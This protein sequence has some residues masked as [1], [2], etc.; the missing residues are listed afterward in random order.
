M[1]T[2]L[3]PHLGLI[4]VAMLLMS[5][6]GAMLGALSYMVRPMFDD[7]FL[8]GDGTAMVLVA[9]VIM[10]LFLT[11]AVAGFGQLVIV[12]R[13]G[14]QVKIAMQS[15]LLRHILRLDSAYFHAHPPG[16]MLERVR[17]DTEALKMVWAT[18]IAS[19]VRDIV[20]LVS[21]FT[22][23]VLI[24]PLWT[25][26]A[27]A[28]VPALVLPIIALLRLT[29]RASEAARAAASDLVI[30]LDEIFHGI[31]QI[32]LNTQEELQAR[33]FEKVTVGYLRAMTQAAAGIAGAP[34]L[35]DIVAG[36]GFV[37]VMIYGGSQIMDGTKTVG[38]FMSFFTAMALVF[39]PLRRL[40]RVGGAWAQARV[41]LMR[42]RDILDVQ[43]T[44][45]DPKEPRMPGS[46]EAQGDITFEGVAFGYDGVPV[47]RGL[48]LTARA[49]ETTA[50]VGPSGAGKSTVFNLLARLADV[51]AGAVRLGGV[52]LRE[53]DVAALRGLLSV[54]SQEAG[55][56]DETIRAN[57][58][59]GRPEAS[60]AEVEAAA[61][62]AF[63][64]DFA[65]TLPA[66]L[67][68]PVGPRGSN[69]SGGQRQRVAIARALLRDAPILLLDEPTSALDTRSE[70]QVQAALE[71]LSRG[72]TTLVIAHR[73]STI[74]SARHIVVLDRGA[75]VDE[76]THEELLSR[77]GLYAGLYAMQFRDDDAGAAP[78]APAAP[79]GGTDVSG[80]RKREGGTA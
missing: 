68:T 59:F 45:S 35:L 54:V 17:G 77:G 36:I 53:F 39:E 66:G 6:E 4:L 5:V 20:A 32:K 18:V 41:S 43:P 65:Q 78:A 30:R 48:N 72:R 70:A 10:A 34:A 47:L 50:L 29:R 1:A 79:G 64:W 40:G 42:L 11:R 75:V 12:T 23:A 52:D 51:H 9:V 3:R 13:V 49:G 33:R 73:L 37:G 60:A 44:I 19:S 15:D 38:E 16:E 62:A 46:A 71:R 61:R 69:L 7:V 25:L 2:Y 26:I 55:L 76:G 63:V 31:A 80:H 58:L 74:R 14:E 24:D 56:F 22:V 8:A 67:D 21:L 28:A 27:V 57:I